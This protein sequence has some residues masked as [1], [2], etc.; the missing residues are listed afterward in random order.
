MNVYAVSCDPGRADRLRA[1]AAP[2]GLNIVIVDSP[3][4]SDPEVVRRGRTCFERDSAYPTG[5]A[6]TL[7]HMRAMQRLVDSGDAW[8][9]I[10]EDDV[11]FHVAFKEIVAS[12]EP[13]L[14]GS[15]DVISL[16]FCNYPGQMDGEVC[17]INGIPFFKN[18][19]LGNPWGAQ[20]YMITR[21]YARRFLDIFREDDVSVPYAYKFVTDC[22][23]F[24]PVLG[25]R[26][27]TLTYPIAVESPEEQSL[28]G[29]Y[30]KYPMLNDMDPSQFYLH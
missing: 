11:R 21:E 15:V 22:V 27:H 29:N 20:C 12:V 25:C 24:D 23:I 1:A 13:L 16:G 17:H 6:A 18:V 9:I 3:L 28:A 30:N 19:S 14:D 4:A 26:R 10:I 5:M 7:G 2:L 8:A